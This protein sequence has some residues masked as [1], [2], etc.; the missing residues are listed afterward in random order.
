M[1]QSDHIDRKRNLEGPIAS[2]VNAVNSSSQEDFSASFAADAVVIDVDRELRGFDAITAWAGADIFGAEVHFE[3]L[4]VSERQGR[5]IVTV[6]VDGTFD[7]TGLPNP[8]VMKHEFGVA[9]GKIA[10]LRIGF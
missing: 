9:E 4:D 1:R 3:V 2:Y 6:R 10:D 5:T 8:L 7:R